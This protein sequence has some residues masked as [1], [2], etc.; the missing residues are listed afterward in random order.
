[1]NKILKTVSRFVLSKCN[2]LVEVSAD[3]L[4]AHEIKPPKS[5]VVPNSLNKENYPDIKTIPEKLKSIVSN[6]KYIFVSGSFSDNIN[7]LEEL[8][9][10]IELL[11]DDLTVIVAGRPNGKW[12][13]TEF[14][15]HRLVRY[16][17]VLSRLKLLLSLANQ[18]LYSLI[19]NLLVIYINMQHPIKFLM[20]WR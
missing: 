2:A 7:G 13:N 10:A 4:N 18:K 9:K 11:D 12:V 20:P 14:I 17:G 3:R 15:R 5:L 1:M 6:K 8:L 19:T 16:I